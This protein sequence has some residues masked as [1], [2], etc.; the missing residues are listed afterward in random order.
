M[1]CTEWYYLFDRLLVESVCTGTS[2]VEKCPFIICF[3]V[4]NLPFLPLSWIFDRLDERKRRKDFI[5]ERNLLYPDPFEKNLSPEER[6]IYKRFKVFTRFHSKE[7]HE[8]FVKSIIEEHRI[9]KRIHELQVW[10]LPINSL[11]LLIVWFIQWVPLFKTN[12]SVYNMC[13]PFLQFRI[14]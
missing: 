1:T 12:K 4:S 6:E 3:E 5:L 8:E 10:C 7:E 11:S 2:F 14:S 9:V 13:T